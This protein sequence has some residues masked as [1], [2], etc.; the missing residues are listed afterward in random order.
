MKNIDGIEKGQETYLMWIYFLTLGSR[1]G[2]SVWQKS[3][4]ITSKI[5]YAN[6]YK[7]KYFSY[8]SHEFEAAI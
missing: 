2:L 8:L 6:K 5:L 1:F 4:M 3:G 7:K